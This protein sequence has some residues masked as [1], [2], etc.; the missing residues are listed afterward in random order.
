MKKTLLVI[1][2][3]GVLGLSSQA[4]AGVHVSIGFGGGYYGPP[5]AYYYDDGP[6]IYFAP[7]YYP[8]YNGYWQ[9]GYHHAGHYYSHHFHH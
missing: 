6:V 2:M 1:G 4:N 7:G 3:M 9:G 5:P 8:W